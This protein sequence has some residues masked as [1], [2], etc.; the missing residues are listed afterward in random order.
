MEGVVII[1]IFRPL[2]PAQDRPSYN[3]ILNLLRVPDVEATVGIH[4][5]RD[6][7]WS[8]GALP[9]VERAGRATLVRQGRL[10]L[11]LGCMSGG[12]AIVRLHPREGGQHA[13]QTRPGYVHSHKIGLVSFSLPSR[14]G[15]NGAP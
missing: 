3:P 11:E 2:D 12:Q 15:K 5:T 4:S 10:Q 9:V 8:G 7:L 6:Q 1:I 13:F 14:D